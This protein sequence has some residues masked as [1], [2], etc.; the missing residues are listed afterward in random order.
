MGRTLSLMPQARAVVSVS[1]L[2]DMIHDRTL[3]GLNA[4]CVNIVEDSIA[5]RAYFKAGANA[6]FFRYGDDSLRECLALVCCKPRAV[7]PIAENG[8]VLRDEY[9]FRFGGY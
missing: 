2:N 3:N 4:G 5:H 7:Y 1:H 8:F 6:L 9:P